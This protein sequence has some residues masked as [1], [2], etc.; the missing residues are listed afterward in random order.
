MGQ[1]KKLKPTGKVIN[2]KG[3]LKANDVYTGI[4]DALQQNVDELK[5][6]VAV[7]DQQHFTSCPITNIFEMLRKVSETMAE[8]FN[9]EIGVQTDAN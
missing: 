8:Q 2:C 4:I 1:K 6:V 9:K 7:G 5:F 3:S